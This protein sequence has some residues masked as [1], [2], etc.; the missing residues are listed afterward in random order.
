MRSMTSS[1]LL[2][3]SQ[4]YRA[5]GWAGL[6]AGSLDITAALV[7]AGLEGKGPVY[8]FQAIAGG[9]L[10][11]ASFQGGLATAALGAF[12]HFLIATTAAAVFYVASRKLKFLVQ[13]AIPSGLLYGV[14]V[15]IFMNYIVL[16]MSA[17]H[18]KIALPPV[19][20]LIRDVAILMFLVGLPI[21]L[22]VRKFSD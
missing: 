7:E 1:P 4:A 5:I 10:G 11:M 15:Y 21:S 3:S 14:A 13:H 19:T 8:L 20:E 22:M 17:Y 9:L 2:G 18:N 6:L 12:F 16:P